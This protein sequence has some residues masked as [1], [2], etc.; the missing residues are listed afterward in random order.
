MLRRWPVEKV[1]EADDLVPA[2]EELAEDVAADEPG[3]AG[4]EDPHPSVRRRFGARA[5]RPTPM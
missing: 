3:A 2:G 5:T 4:D 1:V